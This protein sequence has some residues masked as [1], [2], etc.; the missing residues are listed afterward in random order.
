VKRQGPFLR[1]HNQ[2]GL[3]V[4]VDHHDVDR[5]RKARTLEGLGNVPELG[6]KLYGEGFRSNSAAKLAGEKALRGFLKAL[7]EEERNA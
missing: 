2:S 3:A 1:Q 5:Q 7:S 4:C 6:V